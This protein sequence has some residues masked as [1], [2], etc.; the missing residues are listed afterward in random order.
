MTGTVPPPTMDD[1]APVDGTSDAPAPGARPTPEEQL[2]ELTTRRVALD[3]RHTALLAQLEDA[4]AERRA[5]LVAQPDAPA[6]DLKRHHD[7]IARLETE[8][9][10]VGDA[11]AVTVAD[12]T[13][14]RDALA[15]RERIRNAQ[16]EY[17]EAMA[18][19]TRLRA[20]RL[21]ARWDLIALAV[22]FA[23]ETVPEHVRQDAAA[24][25]AFFTADTRLAKAAEA[26]GLRVPFQ[27]VPDIAQLVTPTMATAF[28]A[29]A[30]A[31][32]DLAI[33]SPPRGAAVEPRD[34]G[35]TGHSSAH[36]VA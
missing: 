7:K 21:A 29:L 27:P 3:A 9:G 28:F 13:R 32:E 33:V 35:R 6:G 24:A 15:A 22:Q 5:L 10:A 16:R 25:D 1:A 31:A 26:V 14:L 23:R 17:Q 11:L 19:Y 18:D 36:P 34:P 8:A 12:E 2:S 4:R 30:R 20:A